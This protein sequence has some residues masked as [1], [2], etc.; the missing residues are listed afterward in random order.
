VVPTRR[1]SAAAPRTCAACWTRP[2]RRGPDK[3]RRYVLRSR[4]DSAARSASRSHTRH[5]AALVACGAWLEDAAPPGSG[6]L[7][8][9]R[10]ETAAPRPTRSACRRASSP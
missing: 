1:T 8:S 9:V 5:S 6:Q 7:P 3:A 10:G 4:R 2:C